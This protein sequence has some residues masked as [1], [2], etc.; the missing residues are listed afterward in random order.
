[1]WEHRWIEVAL[2]DAGPL[3][4]AGAAGWEAVSTVPSGTHFGVTYVAVLLKRRLA[5]DSTIDLVA[6]EAARSTG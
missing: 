3:A 4:E 5:A 2:G 1:M 6:L